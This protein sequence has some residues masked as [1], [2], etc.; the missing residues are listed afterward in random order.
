MYHEIVGLDVFDLF[1][2]VAIIIKR[3]SSA[4]A[5]CHSAFTQRK[6]IFIPRRLSVR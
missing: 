3:E 5:Q 4:I 6:M 1:Y 2:H